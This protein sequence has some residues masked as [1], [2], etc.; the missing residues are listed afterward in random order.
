[1]HAKFKQLDEKK[2]SLAKTSLAV[3]AFVAS[4]NARIRLGEKL[5]IL[6]PRAFY[7]DTDSILYNYDPKL[8][9]IEEGEYSGD[10][11]RENET[12]IVEYCG[13]GPSSY[14]VLE[15]NEKTETKMNGFTLNHANSAKVNLI[16]M[17]HLVD[18]ELEEGQKPDEVPHIS[19]NH[20]IFVKMAARSPL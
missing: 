3:V 1:M 19:D 13:M 4:N 2:T 10:W 7:F 16:T 11:A 14:A 5:G 17:K 6:G 8:T 12:P 18:G 20:H 15:Q 9:N